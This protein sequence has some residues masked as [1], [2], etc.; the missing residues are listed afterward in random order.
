[1]RRPVPS[2]VAPWLHSISG[3]G[4]EVGLVGRGG[5]MLESL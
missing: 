5:G 2:H 3:H 4:G 1:V